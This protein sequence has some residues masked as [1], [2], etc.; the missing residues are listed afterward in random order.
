MTSA[1]PT[2]VTEVTVPSAFTRTSAS[3]DDRQ[4]TGREAPP[5]FRPVADRVTD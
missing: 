3:F 4:E 5:G 2:P 1:L